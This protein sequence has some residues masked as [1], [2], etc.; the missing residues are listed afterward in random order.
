VRADTGELTAA[1]AADLIAAMDTTVLANGET[2]LGDWLASWPDGAYVTHDCLTVHTPP[3]LTVHASRIA[4]PT[5]S[6]SRLPHQSRRSHPF[7]HLEHHLASGAGGT[8]V[9][10]NGWGSGWRNGWTWGLVLRPPS[11]LAED[12]H[13]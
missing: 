5:R 11:G 3:H 8:G 7:R 13:R 4:N 10:W 2:Y 6:G 1:E 12:R 9:F